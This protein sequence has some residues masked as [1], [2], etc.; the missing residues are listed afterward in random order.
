MLRNY[1]LTALRNLRRNPLYTIVNMLGLAVGITC[2]V[3]IMLY[4][5]DEWSFDRYHSKADRIFRLVEK[6]D[7]E[8]QGEESSSNPF[9]TGPALKNDYPAMIEHVVRFFDFQVET[10][11]LKVGEDKYEEKHIFFADSNAFDV[12]DF[13]LKM[14]NPATVLDAPNSIVIS[15]ALADKLFPGQNPLNQQIIYEGDFPLQVTGVFGDIPSQ[16]HFHIEALISFPTLRPILKGTLKGW[17]WNPN[18]TYILL[19]EGSSPEELE[20]HFP[21]FI[22]KYYPGFIRPQIT[23]YLQALTD[24]HLDSDLDYEIEPNGSRST[25]YFLIMIGLF[26]L[27]IACINFMNLATARSARRAREVG[28][29]KVLGAHRG[30]LIRQFLGE[31]LVMTGVSII[32]SLFLIR[33]GLFFF[34]Q[35]AEKQLSTDLLSTPAFLFSLLVLGM[36]VGIVSGLY[37]AYYLSAFRPVDVLKG[38]GLSNRKDQRFRKGLV[39]LQF[40]ISLIL[41]ISTLVIHRQFVYMKTAELGFNAEEVIVIP[42][43]PTMIR[44]LEVLKSRFLQHHQVKY[45]TRMNEMLGV[46]HN[47]HEFNYEGMESKKWVYFPGLMV[48][49]DF[50]ETFDLT[51]VAGRDFDKSYGTDDTT[52]VLV[53]EAMVREL[54]WGTAEDAIGKQLKTPNGNER[55][56]GVLKDF[57]IVSLKEEIRPFVLDITVP[58]L[59][60][61]FTKN[62]AVRIGN[63]DVQQTLAYLAEQWRTVAP[64]HP[65]AYSFLDEEMDA[66]Y[67]SEDRL[68]DLVG[69]FSIL[70]ILIA[71]LGLFALASFTAEQRRHEIGIRRVLG[72]SVPGIASLLTKDFLRLVLLANL[73][74]WP[75]AWWAL[76]QWLEG[77]AYQI[78]LNW[79]DFVFAAMGVIM[80]AVATVAYQAIRAGLTKPARVLREK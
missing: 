77:Y 73:V 34:N 10:R 52:A 26:I 79:S 22:N 64:E 50:V 70:A 14:G 66:L 47:V 38:R 62:I 41:I 23:H 9:P 78:E 11:T 80:L 5:Q 7:L 67:R 35:I 61:F 74:S 21:D 15:Q 58:R 2:F 1:L 51:L 33:F 72:A 68:S 31:S 40:A 48:D 46:H 12:F 71:C 17:V 4:V 27:M 25:L 19:K 8:G 3:W 57:H 54:N 36:I 30:Q 69:Y 75:L 59:K 65:F 60:S 39:V 49:E 28:M 43:K 24:I 29:R 37:P 32:L 18:W 76:H 53:N 55:V 45:V 6:I 20:R 56:A 16:S 44:E 63:Q 42:T 13:P